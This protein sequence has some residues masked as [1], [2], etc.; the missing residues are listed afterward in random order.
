MSHTSVAKYAHELKLKYKHFIEN[1]M[2][3]TK[4]L[5]QENQ[6][7]TQIIGFSEE[8]SFKLFRNIHGI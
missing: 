1:G 6:K 8:G 7:I 4:S 5:C 2:K 3:N